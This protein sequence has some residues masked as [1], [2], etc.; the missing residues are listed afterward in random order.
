MENLTAPIPDSINKSVDYI[1]GK[2]PLQSEIWKYYVA[3]FLNKYARSQYVGMDAVYV[4]LVKNYYA[5][6][7]TPWVDQEKLIKIIDN[8]VRMENTLIG[9]TAPD[10]KLYKED[11]T[12]VKLSEIEAEY[13]VLFFWKPD[14]GHCKASMPAVID[15]QEK[16]RDKGV[17]VVAV[18][19]RLGSKVNECWT[20]EKELKMDKFFLHLADENNLSNFHSEYNIQT[21]PAIFV[22]DKDKK[23]LIKQIPGEKLGEIM[24]NFLKEDRKQ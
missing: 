10:V 18:C 15:F 21:T 1:L 6:G 4:H 11:K 14:C 20:I 3:H 19:T 7:L 8:A 24:D 17:K 12:P 22:L 23:I 13:T 5:K 2:M 9:K 16:Y